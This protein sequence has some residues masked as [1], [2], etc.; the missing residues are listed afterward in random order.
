MLVASSEI[1]PQLDQIHGL[2]SEILTC[3]EN[4]DD[5]M[6]FMII[7]ADGISNCDW[8]DDAEMIIDSDTKEN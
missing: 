1:L 4:S 3:L 7:S 5:W 2:M 8:T 6:R